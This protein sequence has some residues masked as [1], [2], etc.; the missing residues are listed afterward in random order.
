VP[1]A[2]HVWLPLPVPGFDFLAPHDGPVPAS[3]EGAPIRAGAPAS[4]AHPLV[5]ARIAVPWQGGVRVGIA[6]A[7]REVGAAAALDLRPAVAWV[8]DH[9]HLTEAART[10]LA[11]QAAR[12]AVPV[13]VALAGAGVVG[14]R[15]PFEHHVRRDAAAAPELFGAADEAP[16]ADDWT[17]ADRFGPE[18]LA[19]WRAHGMVHERVAEAVATERR[20][21]ARRAEDAG[22]EGRARAGQ[23][24]AL[25]WLERE[26]GAASAAALARDAGVAEGAARALVAKGYAAYVD[27]PAPAPAPPW[28]WPAAS[29]LLGGAADA[30]APAAASWLVTGGLARDRFAA[31]RTAVGATVAAGGQVAWLVP[32]HAAADAVAAALAAGTPTLRWPHDGDEALRTALAREVGRGTPA[33]VVGTFPVL[34]LPFGALGDVVVWDA[35]SA[36]YKGLAGA[37]SVARVDARA[38]AA[39]ADV[40]CVVV[41]PLATAELRAEATGGPHLELARAA[42]RAAVVDLRH[43]SGWP[44]ATPV[45]RLL[46]QVAERGRQA[47]VVAPRRGFAAALGCRACGEVAMCP[48]CDVALRWHARVGRLRCHRC[49]LE[50]GAPAACEACGS[51]DVVPRP[52]A[53]TEWVAD[54]VRRAVPDLL[55]LQWDRDRRD[56]LTPLLEGAPGVIV[57]TTGVLR[58][59]ALPD[60][61]LVALTAG[62]ALLDH[63]DVRATE[64]ALRTLLL[65]PDLAAGDRRP[66]LVAQAHRPEHEVWRAWL[67]DEPDIA[68]AELL[69]GVDRRRAAFGYPPH[70]RWARVQVTHR[71]RARAAAAAQAIVERLKAAGVPADDVLGPAPAAVA[72]SR[73]RYGFHAFV[74]AGDDAG[75]AERVAW[76]D[77]RPLPG[78]LVRVDVDPYDVDVWLD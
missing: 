2:V 21:V 56:D 36:S 61:A 59:P 28:A 37:R 49:G 77:V 70:R 67:A 30:V 9:A 60:L 5:G 68:I 17:P 45:V 40:R 7:V 55:V 24:Q 31:V 48:N 50:R 54:A 42:P 16:A 76:V 8:D 71:E 23:R 19:A 52:G 18:P 11:A 10:M 46:R 78:A 57:G 69:A 51:S 72:R 73:G 14:L 41:D 32:E 34:A 74:R 4:A 13:G 66:L 38:L 47:V 3:P 64:S 75:L 63:E 22:L 29:A 53:G 43:E 25:A 65:L 1:T 58:A 20:L 35:A 39:A 27:A 44:L 12:C 33:I 62:D 6:A 15:G 26:G